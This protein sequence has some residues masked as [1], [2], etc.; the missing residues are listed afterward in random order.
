ML[1]LKGAMLTSSTALLCAMLLQA[2][3]NARVM[4]AGSLEMFSNEL[5]DAAVTVASS[6]AG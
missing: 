5:Y 1:A 2:R 3:N 6:N 4:V